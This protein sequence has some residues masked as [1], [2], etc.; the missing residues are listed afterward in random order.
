MPMCVTRTTAVVAIREL[1]T[2]ASGLQR[3]RYE[4]RITEHVFSPERMKLARFLPPR[5]KVSLEI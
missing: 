1:A 2:N 5:M 3:D 4:T